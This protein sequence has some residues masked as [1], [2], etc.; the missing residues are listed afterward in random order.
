M[1]TRVGNFVIKFHKLILLTSMIITIIMVFFMSRLRL[2]MQFM[3]ILP[4][5]EKTVV[6]YKNAMDNFDTL[7]SIVV[8][9]KGEEGDIKRFIEEKSEGIKNIDGITEV[10]YEN[11]V[12]FLEKNALI[13]MK[14]KD[15]KDM[16]GA[17]TA[18]SLAGLFRG[19]NDNFE[20][21]YIDDSNDEKLD[22][23]RMKLL[24]FLNLLEE[25]LFKIRK[26]TISSEDAK[27]FIRGE[28][29]MISHDKKMGILIVKSGVSINDFDNVIKLVNRL[30]KYLKTEG[31]K[32]NLKVG[33]TGLQV[34]SRD[35]MV[36]SQR[37]MEISSTTSLI[38]ILTVFIIN[39]RVI[40]YSLLALI[41]L[42]SGIIWAMG[43]TYLT[44]GSL[45]M[46]TAMMGAILI[47]LGIDYSIHIISLFLEE[48]NTGK[49]IEE[50]V[51]GIYKKTMKGI[52]TGAL[53]TTIGFLM[54]AFSDFPGFREFGLVLGIG[55]I[56][57][58][59][60]SI[61]LLPSLLVLV[62]GKYRV[63]K[64]RKPAL[65]ERSEYIIIGKKRFSLMAIGL[66]LIFLS[67]KA[68]KVEFEN[69]MLKIEPKNLESVMLNR[70]IIDSFDF[71]S[72]NTIIVSKDLEE[73][74]DVFDRADKLKT[75]GV[76]SSITNF[77]P[78]K[79]KQLR[80]MAA[81]GNL[82][83]S[84]KETPDRDIHRVKLEEELFRVENN[85]I[86]LADL[87]YIGG[88]ERLRKKCDR[89]VESGIIGELAENIPLYRENIEFS[90]EVFI[91]ELQNIIRENNTDS[92]LTLGDLP[93]KIKREYVGEDGTYITTFYP[94][95]DLWKSDFQK[96]HM[97][98][99][100]TLEENIT[101]SAKIFLK[102]IEK[103]A[104]E[105][106]KVLL[107]TVAAIYLVLIMDLRNIKYATAA[108]LPMLFSVLATLGVMG[109]TGFKFDMVNII[110]I[111]LI[112]G[113]GVDDGVH[114]IHRYLREGNIY[115]ALR[116]TGRAVTLTTVTTIAAF[117]TLV[118]ARYRGFVHFGIILVMG[119]A[120]AYIFTL[121]FLVSLISAVDS[122]G[123]ID[124]E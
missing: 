32:E 95:Q 8:V 13:L 50:S 106:K 75:I 24:N 68:G 28:R 114:I 103:S 100:D 80:R 34:L 77:L 67:I 116:S 115:T 92:L 43:I 124:G 104:S 118:F 108:I 15:L 55:I 113:I 27:R 10:T 110:G 61:F 112:I 86:E 51:A 96:I 120:F 71:S 97:K 72:D 105:G 73:A 66:I 62:G 56:S 5:T 22:K 37:D 84:V 4:K 42:I 9:V 89:I 119:V 102:V 87:A 20:K 49:S 52:I 7:D 35:E 76:I 82:K 107:L 39:F 64:I 44:I 17:F 109:W 16:K 18:S 25:L 6:E 54:F 90:Q 83:K 41:P 53:T 30:E 123:D 33:I 91:G 48:R 94:R 12:D 2:N 31:E 88:E 111:P 81:A 70:E 1:L 117:G 36:V 26:G 21:N 69:D 65:L 47:G 63:K 93:E 57:T 74:Q 29:Y 60:S 38:L 58:L 122:I 101:G 45:N 19:I 98:E 59:I 99:I 40:R 85:L 3:D 121:T 78:S 14:K 46:M 11:E 79:E 23:D